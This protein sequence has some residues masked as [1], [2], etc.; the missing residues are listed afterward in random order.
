MYMNKKGAYGYFLIK[1]I[2]YNEKI[3]S[4]FTNK[5]VEDLNT[6]CR[7]LENLLLCVFVMEKE[8]YSGWTK[9][10]SGKLVDIGYSSSTQ[11]LCTTTNNIEA[12]WYPT[13]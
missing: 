12:M 10:H 7:E 9:K 8:D 4:C 2:Q 11:I 5:G 3:K 6:L 13:T 1:K